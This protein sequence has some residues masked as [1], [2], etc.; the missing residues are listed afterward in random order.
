MVIVSAGRRPDAPGAA[1]ARFPV[2]NVVGVRERI[3]AELLKQKPSDVVC[4]AACGSDLLLLDVA[5]EL[6]IR[7]HIVLSGTREDF[8]ASSVADRPGGWELL[9][10]RILDTAVSEGGI[11]VLQLKPG[12][13]GYLGANL[14]IIKLAEGVASQR[15]TH[16]LA[17]A[18]WNRQSRGAEDVTEHFLSTARSKGHPVIELSTLL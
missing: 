8:R 14:E 12:L 6:R 2:Q 16:V 7:R 13:Q 15:G 17:L 1:Q 3:R 18:V 4:A 11:K 9:Y 10:D 5:G